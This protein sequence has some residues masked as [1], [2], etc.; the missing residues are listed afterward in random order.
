MA[1]QF[2]PYAQAIYVNQELSICLIDFVLSV[3]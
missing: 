3:M 2:A 1:Q